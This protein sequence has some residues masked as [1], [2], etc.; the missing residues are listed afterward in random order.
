[1]GELIAYKRADEIGPKMSSYEKFPTNNPKQLEETLR[2]ALPVI[3]T[4]RKVRKLYEVGKARIHLDNVEGLG[5]FMEFEV[6]QK[7]IDLC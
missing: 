1:M 3:G 5:N 2:K 7:V 6:R 4:V